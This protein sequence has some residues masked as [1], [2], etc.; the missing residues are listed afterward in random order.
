MN[1]AEIAI[2]TL[3]GILTVLVIA[4]FAPKRGELTSTELPVPAAIAAS[5]AD[6]PDTMVRKFG[7]A[8]TPAA[9]LFL[10]ELPKNYDI[11]RVTV[12]TAAG[13]CLVTPSGKLPEANENEVLRIRHAIAFLDPRD[14]AGEGLPFYVLIELEGPRESL[15]RVFVAVRLPRPIVQGEGPLRVA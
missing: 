14:E 13:G 5:C 1:R 11:K 8:Y 12:H 10:G 4:Q 9:E 3:A 7:Q 2:A 15:D 6:F